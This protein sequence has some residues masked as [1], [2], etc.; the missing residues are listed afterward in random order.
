MTAR[1]RR[2]NAALWK[3]HF[4]PPS[5]LPIAFRW[6]EGALY[7]VGSFRQFEH[8]V[9]YPATDICIH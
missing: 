8:P 2:F 3:E 4:E 6:F 5:R 7:N 1:L 9:R